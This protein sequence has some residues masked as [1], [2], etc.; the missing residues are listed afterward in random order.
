MENEKLIQAKIID[1][2]K[3]SEKTNKLT[4]TNMLDPIEFAKVINLLK[5]TPHIAYGGYELAERKVIFIGFEDIDFDEYL[6]L[7][8]IESSKELSHRNVLGSILGLGI[9]REMIGDIIINENVCNVIVLKEIANFIVQNLEKV[10]RE[11]VEVTTKI[12]SE[13]I[14]LKDNS[15]MMTITVASP[16]IDAVISACFGVSREMSA[17][18]IRKEK[19]FLN[20]AEVN[21]TSKQV[22]ENDIV[23][24]RGFGRVKI[25]EF[26]GETR[27]NR[28]RIYV[29]KY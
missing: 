21:S 13:L 22:K 11:K 17:E 27:K 14:E 3:L 28:I 5:Q 12:L 15:R 23:S 10:G 2:I 4:Y 7:I 20:H 18:L 29:V 16:R 25:Q 26:S 1:K 8:R 9:K 6:T 19:V 24:V